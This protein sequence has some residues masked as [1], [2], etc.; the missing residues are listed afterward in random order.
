MKRI[1]LIVLLLTGSL[2]AQDM[3]P[4][5][6]AQSLALAEKGD[7]AHQCVVAR[8]Y[9]DGNG[10]SPDAVTAVKWLLK[11]A[12][13]DYLHAII[14]LG[15][16][17]YEG[18]PGV[19][20]NEAES[21]KWFLKAATLGD[22]FA[23]GHIGFRYIIGKGL[24]KNLE[25][26]FKL[27]KKA[28]AQGDLHSCNTLGL[29]YQGG[30]VVPVDYAQAALWFRQAA[31]KDQVDAQFNLAEL[32]FAG[33]GVPQNFETAAKWYMAAAMQENVDALFK[34]GLMAGNG[35]GEPK[36]EV[37]A[38]ACFYA[39]LGPKPKKGDWPDCEKQVALLESRLTGAQITAAKKQRG[40]IIQ[41]IRMTAY[42][43][44]NKSR[45]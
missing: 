26:G 9:L 4:A 33:Q 1:L 28:V 11:A 6:F 22:P 5:K 24:P 16:I 42:V 15:V 29:I 37:E 21:V 38:L 13:K 25:E 36:D 17:Y 10:V 3:T 35:Q 34:L 23:Q 18:H 41:N 39:A 32:Y 19:P 12:D 44:E 8:A 40:E 27:M 14:K 2:S 20:A 45:K 31:D 7:L 30:K 43:K